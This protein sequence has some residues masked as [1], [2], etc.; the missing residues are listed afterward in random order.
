MSINFKQTNVVLFIVSSLMLLCNV[1]ILN[2]NPISGETSYPV[3]LKCNYRVNPI[4][5]EDRNPFFSWQIQTSEN[6]WLQSAYQVIVATN[7]KLLTEKKSDVWNS[8]KVQSG[9]SVSIKYEGPDLNMQQRYY[10]K[11]R[12]WDKNGNFTSWSES[13]FWEMGLKS[14]NWSAKWIVNSESEKNTQTDN[15]RWIWL[16]DQNALDVPDNTLATFQLKLELNE[17][18]L[19]AAMQTVV[20][21]DYQLF[22]NGNFVDSKDKSWQVFE[23]QDILGYLK[24]GKNTVEIKVAAKSNAS[25]DQTS[26]RPLPGNYAAVAA[27]LRIEEKSGEEIMYPTSCGKWLSKNN[28]ESAWK[29][30]KI[31]GELNNPEFG[32][33]PGPLSQPAS[34]FR[35][36]FELKK[37]IE[38][39]RLYVTALGSYRFFVNGE[40]VGEDVLTPEFT[41][42]DSRI[43]Y[44]TYDIT[45]LLNKGA[46]A[47]G[48][49]LGD[50][51]YGSPLGWNGE[52]DLWGPG[53]NMF[54]AEIHVKYKSGAVEKIIT[55]N[56][57]RTHRSPILKSEIYSGEYYDA[58]LEQ[59]GWSTFGFSDKKWSFAGVEDYNYDLITPQVNMPVRIIQ[60]TKPKHIHKTKDDR[61]IIDMGQNLVGWPVLKVKGEEGTVI[62]M[63][64]SEILSSAD[65]LYVDNLRNAT[66]SD[67]YVLKGDG[68]ELY[69]PYFTFHGFRYMEVTGYPGQLTLEAIVAEVISSVHNPTGTIQTSDTL[70]NKMYDLGIWGQLGNFISVPTDCP[71]RDERLGYTGDGQVFWRTGTYNFDVAAFAHKWMA[72]IGDEQTPDGGIPNTAPAVPKSNRK[73]GAP[74]WEDAVVIVPWNTWMQYGDKSIIEKNWSVM[75]RYMDYVEKKSKDFIR[76]GYFLGDHLAPDF[77][78]PG[79]LIS[80]GLWGLT[81]GMMAQMAEATERENEAEKYSNLKGN[82]R[83]AFQG[84][85][86][87]SDGKFGSGSQASYA[88]ALHAGMVPDSMKQRTTEKLVEAIEKREWHVS[89]G[90]IGTPYL[91]FA[92]SENGRA[93]VAYRLLLN[94]SYPSWGYMI[95]NGAT[96]WWERWNSDSGDP[97][98]NSFNHY[99]F[100]S[101]VEWIY[102]SLLGINTDA[103]GPGFKKVVINPVFD[104]SGKVTFAKGVYQSVYGEIVSEW[105]ILSDSSVSLKVKIPANTTGTIQMPLGAK[106]NTINGGKVPDQNR[107]MLEIGSGSY[108]FTIEI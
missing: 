79:N 77:S 60:T 38:S 90:F 64:F 5:L 41:N 98:M 19:V 24:K 23:R 95:K 103:E 99:A 51:W 106:I 55:D 59:E 107:T 26:S 36:E 43:V 93:D 20:R 44:Q 45:E 74:G 81:A 33:N 16:P 88:I 39:A 94:E 22:V 25:F 62:K 29:S 96:T 86:I 52:Y 82:I 17:I 72:D 73:N 54:L 34:L 78:T 37:G 32:L 31:V 50:G 47:A 49:I 66:V 61:W 58:R 8:G 71:Q 92:L 87:A 83:E 6:N 12:V 9:E 40:R 68:E 11:V 108:Q 53:P 14:N 104:K 30:S 7:P 46:N 3:A 89:T 2:A 105:N 10:W 4:G 67:I 35:K 102:R 18:P 91:L 56:S 101:V 63:R 15:I 69:R 65:S 70:L 97:S 21:G 48:A 1:T 84:K 57:W 42:Y 85:F 13:A 28:N 100:G 80:T 75:E 27:L 76:P